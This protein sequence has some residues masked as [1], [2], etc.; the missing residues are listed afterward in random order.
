MLEYFVRIQ[1]VGND[2][3]SQDLVKMIINAESKDEVKKILLKDYPTLFPNSNAYQKRSKKDTDQIVFC[4]IYELTDY[5]KKFWRSKVKCDCCGI[6]TEQIDI[7]QNM[8]SLNYRDKKFCSNECMEKYIKENMDSGYFDD[9]RWS[10]S[11]K[12]YIYKITE[13]DSNKCYIGITSKHF[14]WRWWYHITHSK[15]PFGEYLKIKGEENFTYEVLE[16]FNKN[17]V[18]KREMELKESEYIV[19]YDSICNGFNTVISNKEVFQ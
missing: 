18:S 4:N 17:E 8:R 11:E 10:N 19:K 3:Y 6:E 13:K 16:M 9:D 1:T 7:S 12:Y 2:C 14:I 15:S 5:Y